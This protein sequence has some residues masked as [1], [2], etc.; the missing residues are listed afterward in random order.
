MRAFKIQNDSKGNSYFE[1]GFLPEYVIIKSNCFIIQT[2]IE[3]YQ[4]HQHTAPREQYV[5]TLKGKLKFTTSDGKQF[6]IEPGIILIA[7]DISGAGHSWE[8]MEGDDWQ[9]IYIIPEQNTEDQFT[10]L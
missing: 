8:L 10:A 4:K 9:R 2:K 5:I 3:D 1:E 7:K 6:I